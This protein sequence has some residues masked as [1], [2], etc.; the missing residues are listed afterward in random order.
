MASPLI[1]WSIYTVQLL[2]LVFD[3]SSRR[4][5][6]IQRTRLEAVYNA[7]AAGSDE[8]TFAQLKEKVEREEETEEQE[9]E[10]F[11]LHLSLDPNSGTSLESE[12]DGPFQRN[13]GSPMEASPADEPPQTDAA[14]QTKG[15]SLSKTAAV[16]RNQQLPTLA[17]LVVEPDSQATSQCTTSS[18]EIQPVVRIEKSPQICALSGK[19]DLQCPLTV[20]KVDVPTRK[21]RR[22]NRPVRR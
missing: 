8:M 11:C 6:V 20:K 17:Q 18:Q 1:L 12:Q 5:S 21:R 7:L 10:E 19:K 9:R 3:L 16:M 22:V 4:Q 13:S 2:S 14:T 15:G